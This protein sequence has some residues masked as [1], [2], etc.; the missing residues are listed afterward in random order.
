MIPVVCRVKHDPDNGKYGDC[1]RA[2]IASVLEL[3]A[4]QVPHFH[5]DDPDGPTA[6][7]RITAFLASHRLAPFYVAYDGAYSMDDILSLMGEQN[8]TAVYLLFG[9]TH[10]GGHVVVCQGGA[11]VHDPAWSRS[12]LIGGGDSGYWSIMVLARI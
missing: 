1:V 12:P 11:M 7:K 3:D 10:S 5:D 8:P 6:T 2:C 9:R 4:D